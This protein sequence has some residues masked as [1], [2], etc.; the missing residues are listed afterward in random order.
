MNKPYPITALCNPLWF[1]IV[2][3]CLNHEEMH[4]I[5]RAY[6]LM[7]DQT[8]HKLCCRWDECLNINNGLFNINM[9]S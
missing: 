2:G 5:C 3:T 9:N 6:R 4:H 1:F 7:E 8:S